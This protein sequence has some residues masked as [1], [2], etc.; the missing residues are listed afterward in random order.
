MKKTLLFFFIFLF[1]LAELQAQNHLPL[2]T[3]GAQ[4]QVLMNDP[5]SGEFCTAKYFYEKDTIVCGYNYSVISLQNYQECNWWRPILLRSV[6]DSVFG[7]LYT[8]CIGSEYLLYDFSL[9][10]GDTFIVSKN[11]NDTAIVTNVTYLT[12][13][14]G[15]VRKKIT[16][17]SINWFYYVYDWIEGIGDLTSLFYKYNPPDPV[18]KLLC[19]QDSSGLVYKDSYWNICDTTN[20]TVIN[21]IKQLTYYN[22]MI[23]PNPFRGISKIIYNYSIAIQEAQ[24]IIY[25][26]TGRIVKLVDIA[27]KTGEVKLSCNEFS[28]GFY[29]CTLRL[30]GVNAITK[31]IVLIK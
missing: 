19:F 1:A 3:D 28:E 6:G 13:L 29:F 25:D 24:I 2:P 23:Y 12:M 17:N 7:R 31:K 21:E 14:N 11:F 8:D 4:W 15:Q 30:D 18:L 27:D 5:N 10:I 26:L 20:I 9:S 16:L 22:L